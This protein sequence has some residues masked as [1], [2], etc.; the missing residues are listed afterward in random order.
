VTLM[1]DNEPKCVV[2]AELN[3]GTQDLITN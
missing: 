2:E 3:S 1:D